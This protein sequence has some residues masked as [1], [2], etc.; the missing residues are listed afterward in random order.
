MSWTQEQIKF[1][2]K[3]GFRAEGDTFTALFDGRGLQDGEQYFY[4]DGLAVTPGY[5]AR[6]LTK[7]SLSRNSH[8]KW[9]A[10]RY[11]DGRSRGEV[12]TG[13][14]AKAAWRCALK[15]CAE[16]ANYGIKPLK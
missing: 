10:I 5:G 11:E 1:A 9:S 4:H 13:A 2:E 3:H 16:L 7:V 12:Y 14:N 8:G 6:L 15:H